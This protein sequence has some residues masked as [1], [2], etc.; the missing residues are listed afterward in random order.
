MLI[1]HGIQLIPQAI[2]PKRRRRRYRTILTWKNGSYAFIHLSDGIQIQNRS[3]FLILVHATSLLI[4]VI[5]TF[6]SHWFHRCF[7]NKVSIQIWPLNFLLN[8]SSL[9]SINLIE[10]FG[11]FILQMA[12]ANAL[13]HYFIFSLFDLQDEIV[14]FLCSNAI[15]RLN[16]ADQDK[17][18]FQ[19]IGCF[20][21][22]FSCS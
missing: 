15:T 14:L 1:F 10:Y 12:F 6:S 7:S 18:L 3:R 11:N 17:T 16:L 19:N 20:A 13:H 22:G 5:S 8:C 21:R 2:K 9:L 4:R